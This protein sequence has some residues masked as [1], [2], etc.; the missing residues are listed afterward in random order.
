MFNIFEYLFKT[1]K[2]AVVYFIG[3]GGVGMYSLARLALRAGARVYGSERCEGAFAEDLSRRG[4]RIFIGHN[5]KNIPPDTDTVVYSHAISYDNPELL[6]ARERGIR[7]Y[8]R[9]EL[10]G[11]VMK[12]YKNRIGVSG[13][14][15]KSTVTGMIAHILNTLGFSPTAAVGAPLANGLPFLEGGEEYLVYEACEYRDS[16]LDFYPTTVVI[17]NI[18]LDHTDYFSS[19]E[20]YLSSFLKCISRAERTC[21]LNVDDPNVSSLL[22]LIEVDTITVGAAESA[23][24][25]YSLYSF[26]SDGIIYSLSY[27]NSLLGRYKLNL[28]GEFN[29]MNAALAIAAVQD[30]GIDPRDAAGALESFRGVKRRCEA[31]GVRGTRT[32][33]YD[34]AHHP[35]EI[36]A[37]INALRMQAG[38][39]TVIFTPH[40]YTRTRD[41]WDD[42]VSALS[43]ADFVILTDIYAAR[44]ARIQS[45]NSERL[46]TAIGERATYSSPEKITAALDNKT[47]GDIVVMGAGENSDILAMILSKD[48]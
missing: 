48:G 2:N 3:I 46:A 23:T 30:Y 42:F 17:T 29:V 27:N 39:I 47:Y 10:L 28:L 9:S 37:V 8:S 4:C 24:V 38:A 19:L 21:V 33:Y 32:V 25:S 31:V 5:E 7:T 26:L 40:T 45:V 6:A 14:H 44:E 36:R 12:E 11:L 15:G 18:E 35:T 43:L 1:S 34:Y 41:L 20:E 22:P 16:F 13:T